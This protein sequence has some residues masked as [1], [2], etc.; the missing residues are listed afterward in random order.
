MTGRAPEAGFTSLFDGQT[1]HGWS[2]VDG[3][4]SAFYVD[5]GAIVVHQGSNF[6]CWLRSGRQY[7][8][9]DFRGEYFI[10]GWMD[11]GIC[12]HA[13]EHGR[14]IWNGMEFHLFHNNE[15][16]PQVSSNGA[17][18]PVVPPLKIN[19]RNKGEWNDFRLLMEWP[20]FQAW[21]NGELVQDLDLERNPELR[22]RFRR[23][24]LGFASLSYPIRFRN[25]RIRELPDKERWQVLYGGPADFDKWTPSQGG[26]G[27]FEALGAVLR[28]DG[29]GSFATREKFKDFEL[30]LY[31]R[32]HLHHNSGV[33]F[34]TGGDGLQSKNHYEIQ[35]HDVEGAHYPT[36]SLYY[37]KRAVYPR[38][39]AYKWWPMHVIVK[40]AHLFV[41]INGDTVLEYDGLEYLDEGS[42]EL[43]AHSPGRWTEFKN[44]LVKRL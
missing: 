35:L 10:R 4:E 32:H 17:I 30:R 34:R 22:C 28:C 40:G 42:I 39:E 25:L 8:N 14:T 29:R 1:L 2:I 38:I 20:K 15:E 27:R 11:S 13:P 21:T 16:K 7:E 9:F 18:L 31:V 23:G 36:G 3:P 19:V 41:R 24:Y 33:L 5:G 6:P 37:F 12:I 44:V 43:Q 26:E